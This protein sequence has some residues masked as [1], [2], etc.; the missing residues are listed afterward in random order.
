MNVPY[1]FDEFFA[2]GKEESIS[3]FLTPDSRRLGRHLTL[4][5]AIL[6]AIL[7]VISFA[8]LF[9]S[10]PASHLI[11]AGVYF[12]AGTP[13]LLNAI[14][15][16]RNMEI[17]I[18]VLMTLAALLSIAIGSGMEGALLLVLFELSGAMENMVS[19]KT[20]GALLSLQRLTPKIALVLKEDGTLLERSVHEIPIGTK[21]LIKAGEIIPLDGEVIAGSSF[22]NLVHLTGES[23]PLSK[24]AGDTLQA[25]ARNL[26]GSLTLKVTRK[27][28]DSTLVRIITLITE[29]QSAKPKLERLFDR[30]GKWYSMTIIALSFFFALSLPFLLTM[31]FLGAEG[32]VYRALTFLIAASPCAL[33][34]A[35]PTA[36]LSAISSCARNGILLKGGVILDALASCTM[37]AFD[38]TGTLT[39]GNLTCTS[40]DPLHN[41]AFDEETVIAIASGLEKHAVHPVSTAI[42]KYAGDKGILPYEIDEFLA[43]PGLGLKGEIR[44]K[45]ETLPVAIGHPSLIEERL[46]KSLWEEKIPPT[47]TQNT[48]L[49]IGDSLYLFHFED[50]IR[51][52]A[53]QALP[54]LKQ[55]KDLDLVLLTG[56]H[57]ENA[58]IVAKAL[59]IE[60]VYSDL[61]PEDKLEK[62]AALSKT[63]RLVMVGDGVNDAP[64]LARSTVGVSMGKIGSATAVDASDIVI[65][66]D[67]LSLLDWVINKSKQTMH[68]VKQNLVLALAV[69]FLATTPALLGFIPLWLAVVLHEGGTVIVGLN[70]LRLLKK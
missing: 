66:K 3:P 38:K 6:S 2:S 16:L 58:A 32:S 22:V 10:P 11:L 9:I 18:D 33:I 5:S 47:K 31:P 1:I 4:K 19:Q 67:D 40:V 45:D 55:N 41:D 70:S 44:L 7:L 34:I 35:I 14:D 13:A 23:Q 53:Y 24:K 64:A 28:A 54:R 15:D 37:I 65:L 42:V 17:N 68:I 60:E 49:L 30:F 29:A 57:S 59:Q 48:F 63:K 36:Y 62:V 12:L 8:L 26:D 39:T 61:R 20:K 25:G 21:I 52:E 27:A 43:I 46:P 56:D 69:I 51:I 50:E